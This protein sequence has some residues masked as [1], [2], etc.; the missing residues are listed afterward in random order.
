MSS[1]D[2]FKQR[3]LML[4]SSEK[5][6]NNDFVMKGYASTT[7]TNDA[8]GSTLTAYVYNKQEKDEGYIYTDISDPLTVGSCWEAK[9]LHFLIAEEIVIMKEV[10]FHKYYALL[11]NINNG[12][13]WWYF[14]KDDYI[15]VSLRQ[16]SF[17]KSLAKPLLVTP[18]TPFGYNDKVVILNRAWL[19]QEYDNYSQ[20]GITYYSITPTTISK[21]ALEERVEEEPVIEQAEQV[22]VKED[23][24][25][26][27]IPNHIY[28]LVTEGGYFRTS[29]NAIS[30]VSR[31]STL[32]KFSIPFGVSAVTVTVKQNGELVEFTYTEDG[33]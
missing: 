27:I 17:I 21:D 5:D 8:D 26:Q 12:N 23:S 6:I 14:K 30:I 32:V 31:T 10:A 13:E 15:D 25:Y 9:G 22:E 4:N 1:F 33:E 2:R 7:I 19:V 11:C 28:E 20:P 16:D 3:N 24:Q 29:S 18:G